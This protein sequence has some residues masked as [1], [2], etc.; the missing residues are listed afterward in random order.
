MYNYII[1][2]YIIIV[3]SKIIINRILN[4]YFF[5]LF[6]NNTYRE[7]KGKMEDLKNGACCQLRL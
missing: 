5:I 1:K 2:L 3:N 7:D 6:K 4:G